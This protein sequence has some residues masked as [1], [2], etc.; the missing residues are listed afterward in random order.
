MELKQKE[1]L[2]LLKQAE[3][4]NRTNMELKQDKKTEEGSAL[5]S[6]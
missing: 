2:K 6:F 5:I 4:F 1:R 3:T